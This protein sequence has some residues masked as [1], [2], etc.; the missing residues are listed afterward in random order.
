MTVSKNTN[1]PVYHVTTIKDGKPVE[2]EIVYNPATGEGSVV[3]VG[4]VTGKP[5][6]TTTEI[7]PVTGVSEITITNTTTIKATKE[8]KQIVDNLVSTHPNDHLETA[9][10]I[11]EKTEK[12]QRAVV[13]T[14]VFQSTEKTVQVT[15]LLD[16]R[17]KGI[18]ELEYEVLTGIPEV[19]YSIP[20][21]PKEVVYTINTGVKE[22][23]KTDTVLVNVIG[24]I[25]SVDSTLK[26][27]VPT[28]IHTEDY[29]Q[30][31]L[32]TVVYETVKANSRILV[33]YNS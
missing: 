2:I 28:F 23:I 22:L 5:V 21:K 1:L 30:S 18:V 3:N 13:K 9:V 11:V 16:Q 24:S 6:L 31:S 7:K 10:P 29:L 20:H 25:N 19:V 15:Y 12:Y 32:I 4:I 14:V 26:A 33:V 8:Y 27:E 17:T